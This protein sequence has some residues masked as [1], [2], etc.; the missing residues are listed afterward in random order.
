MANTAPYIGVVIPHF[1]NDGALLRRS[2]ESIFNQTVNAHIDIVIVDDESPVSTK[3]ITRDLSPPDGISI[4]VIEQKNSGPGIARNTGL[5]TL[6]SRTDYVAFLDS[7]DYWSPEHLETAM[8]AF[9]LGAQFYFC[10]RIVEGEDED[11][12]KKLKFIEKYSLDAIEGYPHLYRMKD[13]YFRSVIEGYVTTSTI[14]YDYQMFGDLRF[15][16]EFY[17]FGE[18]QFLWLTIGERSE[19]II[20]SDKIGLTYGK[21]VSIFSDQEFGTYKDFYR[22]HDE[23]RYRK[24]ALASFDFGTELEA[25]VEL[26]LGRAR[27][28]LSLRLLHKLRRGKLQYLL[29]TLRRDPI[30]LLFSVRNVFKIVRSRLNADES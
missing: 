11:L 7:D 6:N 14:I 23:I 26:R 5:A 27:D 22:I 15:P 10:S 1:Q 30:V 16:T 29:D 18:D 28:R 25:A 8:L 2:L 12:F 17:R 9:N 13:T 3:S 21:G 19:E 4:A 24:K 20:L